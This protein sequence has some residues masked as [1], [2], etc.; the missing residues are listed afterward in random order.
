MAPYFSGKDFL[1][2]QFG[3]KNGKVYDFDVQEW[4]NQRNGREHGR[5]CEDWHI[6]LF[7]G[8]F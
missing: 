1:I 4:A 2:Q 7:P 6:V 5:G 3:L 8:F